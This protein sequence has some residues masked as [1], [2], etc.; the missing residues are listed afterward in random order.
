MAYEQKPGQG[1]LFKND[2][3]TTDVGIEINE[4]YYNNAVKHFQEQSA[5]QR[6]F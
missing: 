3:K 4:T 2:K 6:L 1:S 5:Q